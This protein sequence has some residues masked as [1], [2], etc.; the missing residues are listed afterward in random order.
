MGDLA[1]FLAHGRIKKTLSHTTTTAPEH[2]ATANGGVGEGGGAG[3]GKEAVEK[4]R[5]VGGSGV[6]AVTAGE[7]LGGL[8]REERRWEAYWKAQTGAKTC[9][10][11]SGNVCSRSLLTL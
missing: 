7:E 8:E 11:V 1:Y 3:T 4:R 6:R 5:G 9:C 2:R 10:S